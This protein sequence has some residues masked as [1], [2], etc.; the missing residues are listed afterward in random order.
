[1][2]FE[3]LDH[4]ADVGLQATGGSIEEA[5]GEAARGLFSVMVDI[6]AV[7]RCVAH[8]VHVEAVS[9]EDLLVEWLGELVAQRE[10]SGLVFSEFEVRISDRAGRVV[11]DGI[12]RGE[13]LDPAV[14]RAAAE[15]KGISYL[16]LAVRRLA[17]GWSVRCVVDV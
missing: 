14:H 6:E 12:A 8:P 1:M 13:P 3:V 4:T 17:D 5:F 11:L 2:P 7:R 16:G 15:V 9:Y 10:L